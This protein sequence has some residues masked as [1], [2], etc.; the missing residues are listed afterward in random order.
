[1]KIIQTKI[2]DWDSVQDFLE[3]EESIKE[4]DFVIIPTENGQEIAKVV[5]IVNREEEED[6]ENLPE[7]PK[8]IRRATKE[9]LTR[10]P[11]EEKK[12]EALDYCNE[13]IDKYKLAMKLVDVHFSFSNSK[14]IFSF[15]ADGRI[16]FRELVKDL[17]AHFNTTIRLNQIGIRDEAKINGDCGH[18][19]RELCCK[20]FKKDFCSITSEM[21]ETQQVVHRGSDRISGM[22]GRLMCCL[23]YE[24]EGYEYLAKK[25]PKIGSKIS[26][27]GKKGIV[28]S[29]KIL[30]QTVL[31]ET[32]GR[33]REDRVLTEVSINQNKKAE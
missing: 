31:V 15:I 1:M 17:T 14:M 2:A 3:D 20:G 29:Q 9:D 6:E 24:Q 16:D 18:C 28:V 13:I 10:I 8:I 21:A 4:I 7:L 25:M 30:K 22:C 19:G 26:A 27:D 23:S 11:S 33:G 5:N 12:E 32:Q